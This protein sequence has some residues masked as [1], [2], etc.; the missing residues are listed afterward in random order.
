MSPSTKGRAKTLSHRFSALLTLMLSLALAL[1]LAAQEKITVEGRVLD[2]YS[3]KGIHAANVHVGM[4]QTMTDA[5]GRFRLINV[6][7]GS[8]LHVE[9]LG[10]TPLILT[11]TESMYD[12]KL[13]PAPVLLES[14]VVQ[15]LG[16]AQLAHNSALAVRSV[17]ESQIK[18]SG[19]TSLAEAM[20]GSE[21]VSVSRVGSWGSRLSLRGLSGERLAVM[22]DGMRVSRACTYG[23]DMG[24][25]TIDPATV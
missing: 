14:M 12:L 5:E 11:A 22:I 13:S 8:E 6:P 24:L 4:V 15:A 25:A 9:R 17:D 1:P 2:A 16:D 21:G 7:E 19:L 20:D 23:M 10:Y 18:T 3:G